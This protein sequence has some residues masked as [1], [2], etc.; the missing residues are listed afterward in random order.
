MMTKLLI[1]NCK[2][3]Y[4]VIVWLSPYTEFGMLLPKLLLDVFMSNFQGLIFIFQY[5]NK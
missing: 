3:W 4:E 2:D 5:D 1:S